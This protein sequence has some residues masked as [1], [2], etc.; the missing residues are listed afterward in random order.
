LLATSLKFKPGLERL[1]IFVTVPVLS[2]SLNEIRLSE[3]ILA[4]NDMNQGIH[5]PSTYVTENIRVFIKQ[6]IS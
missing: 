2:T 5:D 6:I 3:K 4:L 1:Q